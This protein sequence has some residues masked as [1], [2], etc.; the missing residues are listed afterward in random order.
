V[1]E[2]EIASFSKLIDFNIN[3]LIGEVSYRSSEEELRFQGWRK[4][5]E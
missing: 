4:T 1:I 5:M 3:E 2:L